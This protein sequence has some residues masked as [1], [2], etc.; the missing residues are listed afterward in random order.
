MNPP[1]RKALCLIASVAGLSVLPAIG[2][3]TQKFTANN[4]DSDISGVAAFND[5]NLVDPRGLVFGEDAK[6][7]W[8][9]NNAT[10][11][12]T[13]YGLFG[14]PFVVSGATTP[15]VI[16]IPPANGNSIGSPTGLIIDHAAFSTVTGVA[17]N[18]FLIPGPNGTTVPSRFV[19]GS[20]DGVVCGLNTN[21]TA[22]S[23]TPGSATVGATVSGADY[24]GAAIAYVNASTTTSPSYQHF[25]FAANFATGNVDVF[26]NAFQPV[27]LGT[28]AFPGTFSDADPGFAPYNVKRYSRKDPLTGKILRVLLVAYAKINP[29]DTTQALTGAGNGYVTVFSLGAPD[30]QTAGTKVGRLVANTG[31]ANGLNVPWGMALKYGRNQA[32]DVVLVGNNGSGE[33]HPFSLAGVFGMTLS[34]PATD[35]GALL[36]YDDQ[37]LDFSGLWALHFQ[38]HPQSLPQFSADDDELDSSDSPLYFSAGLLDGTHG[39]TGLIVPS[40]SR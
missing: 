5:A 19:S 27:T 16:T 38:P 30:V 20:Q 39:L 31:S 13:R 17:T 3:P 1:S 35:Q 21:S 7:F 18:E 32:Q 8:V 12:M 11:T 26:T 22:G 23:A 25:L 14:Q 28:G 34:T 10:G 2:E 40:N 4:L 36:T 6:T 37:T 9:A 24:K 29:Q 15:E 33:I